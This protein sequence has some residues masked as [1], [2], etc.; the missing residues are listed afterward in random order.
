MTMLSRV[1]ENFYWLGRYAERAEN[2][3][4]ITMVN[5][6]LLLDLPKGLTPGW[7]SLVT[8]TGGRERFTEHYPDFE[9]RHVVR[10]LL[11]DRRNPGSMVSSLAAARE[12]ART[13]REVLP[14]E[15]WALLNELYHHAIEGGQAGVSK[16]GRY[17]YLQNVVRG[18]QTLSGAL[19]GTMNHD[20]G[21]AFLRTGR[22]LERGD[23]T[24]R[25]VDVRSES[26]LRDEQTGLP[27][28]EGAQWRSVLKSLSGYQMYRQTMHARIR[29]NAV[30]AFLL[31]SDVF[32]RAVNRCL[33]VI[34]E[35]LSELPNNDPPR[36][37]A[38]SVRRMIARADIDTL[39][40]DKKALR[41][42]LD[43]LQGEFGE[44]HEDIARCWFL[45]APPEAAPATAQG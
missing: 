21:Y 18:V 17:R 14:S 5:A 41:N 24:T 34:D 39:A 36:R 35:S 23:M 22:V 16:R 32:P 33:K 19:L 15:A 6:N 3:A 13:V 45:A 44:L 38:A 8:I 2:T 26:L 42:F 9:E 25:I 29:R 7:A 31:Q 28:F 43:V 11:T 10:F 4:R 1:A 20:E 27:P 40:V 30:L 37:L 12:N